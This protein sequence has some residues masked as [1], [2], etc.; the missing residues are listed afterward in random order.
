M[1]RITNYLFVKMD[2]IWSGKVEGPK[3]AQVIY[4]KLNR[5][6]INYFTDTF[7][8]LASGKQFTPEDIADWVSESEQEIN[9]ILSG[10]YGQ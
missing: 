5:C 10:V 8:Q 6:L 4:A 2:G 9:N 1:S 7:E 3:D